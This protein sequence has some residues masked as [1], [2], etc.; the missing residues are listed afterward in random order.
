[1]IT[2]LYFGV[3]K[4]APPVG[5]IQELERVLADAVGGFTA[6]AATSVWRNPSTLALSEE[7]SYVY[8]IVHTDGWPAIHA[9]AIAMKDLLKQQEVLVVQVLSEKVVL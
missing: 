2:K 8:E 3:P 6:Y 9:F 1:M 7:L 4:E 5:S